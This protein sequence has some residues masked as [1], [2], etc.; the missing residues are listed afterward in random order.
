VNRSDPP[1]PSPWQ[2]V[3]PT[4]PMNVLNDSQSFLPLGQQLLRAGLITQGQLA[5]AL[6]EQRENFM[7]F[8]E[9]CLI[10]RW[11]TIEDL[12]RHTASHLL[13]LGEILIALNYIDIDQLKLALSQQRRFGRKLGEILLWKS[14][15]TEEH[16]TYALRVQQHLRQAATPN[17][18]EA[19]AYYLPVSYTHLTLPTTERV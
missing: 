15:V 2:T 11:I 19:L 1:N 17:A 5:Q 12:Y 14:W 4:T 13:S 3:H 7:K 6:R 16:L 18:W 10:H 9:V 8:G